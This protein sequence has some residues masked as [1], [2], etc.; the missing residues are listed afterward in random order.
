MKKY[1]EDKKRMLADEFPLFLAENLIQKHECPRDRAKITAETLI[2]GKKKVRD[3]EYAIV[4]F[5]PS[6]RKGMDESELSDKEKEEL[7]AE[8]AMKTYYHYY[9]RVKDHWVKDDTIGEESFMDTNSLFCNIDFKCHKNP[10]VN[11]CD[12]EKLAEI[13]MKNKATDDA[14]REFDNR[15]SMTVDEM[16]TLLEENVNK[17]VKNIKK[18][19]LLRNHSCAKTNQDGLCKMF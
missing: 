7:E 2:E 13:R 6:V 14:L 3:G 19:K 12:S 11:T 10:A 8:S 1:Q 9:R 5:K 16:K 4:E 15:L 18:I 17:C